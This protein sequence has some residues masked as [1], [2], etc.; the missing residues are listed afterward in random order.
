MTGST[1]AIESE[2][3]TVLAGPGVARRYFLAALSVIAATIALSWPTI[4]NGQPFLL[5]DTMTYIRGA[6]AAV[7]RLT[8][9]KTDWTP[10]FSERFEAKTANTHP[11]TAAEPP[12][13]IAGRSVYYG[14][15]LYAMDRLAGLRLA[16]LAQAFLAAVCLYATVRRFI[17]RDQASE[18]AFLLVTLALSGTSSVAFFASYLVP[19][20]FAALGILA[21]ANLCTAP[22]TRPGAIFWTNIVC[23]S[24]AFHTA[25]ISILA[26][27]LVVGLVVRAPAAWLIA[28]GVI[29]GI[30]SEAAFNIAVERQFGNAP[31]RPPFVEARLIADGIGATYLRETC[32]SSGFALCRY[33]NR[34]PAH[35]DW[36]YSDSFLW[37]TDQSSGV[38]SAVEPNERR[39]IAAEQSRFALAVVI[40]HPIVVIENASR[41]IA[42]QASRWR[43]D[44][45]NPNATQWAEFAAGLPPRVM[46]E[47][48]GTLAFRQ[49]MPVTPFEALALATAFASLLLVAGTFRTADK[50]AQTFAALL[51]VGIAADV[52]ICGALST[53]HGRYLMRIVWL[54]PVAA[55]TLGFRHAN[56]WRARPPLRPVTHGAEAR[57]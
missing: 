26:V 56:K 21:A 22:L 37:S 34:F 49:A 10:R 52:A 38:F 27:M 40:A 41:D 54:L 13:I 44:E 46:Q 36:P 55:F 14:A 7:Y 18:P 39:R 35:R 6:D 48:R 23:L 29:V 15:F 30:A 43:L 2:T 8:G 20:L 57:T 31:V 45:F 28:F 9:S 11:R 4:I 51:L 5:S 19:D 53:P 1:R 24:A 33:T 50:R 17:R 12:V 25:N 3:R 47:Q 42:E 16:A 32:P